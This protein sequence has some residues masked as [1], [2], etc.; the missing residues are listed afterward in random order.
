MESSVFFHGKG[1]NNGRIDRLANTLN[2]VNAQFFIKDKR[3][4]RSIF[5]PHVSFYLLT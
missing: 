5:H 1:A 4:T 3:A 2:R